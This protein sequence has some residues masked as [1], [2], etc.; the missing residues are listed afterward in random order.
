MGMRRP[1]PEVFLKIPPQPLEPGVKDHLARCRLR[2]GY[3]GES[4]LAAAERDYYVRGAAVD[5]VAY[6]M[7]QAGLEHKL[8]RRRPPPL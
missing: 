2:E 4:T 8:P 3:F 1:M 5:Y 7:G 6:V